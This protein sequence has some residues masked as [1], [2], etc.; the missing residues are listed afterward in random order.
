MNLKICL[1]KKVLLFYA[2][3]S[4]FIIYGSLHNVIQGIILHTTPT[5][6]IGPFSIFGFLIMPFLLVLTYIRNRS[7]IT[8]D[9]MIIYKSVYKF[10]DYDFYIQKKELAF[11]DRPITSLFKKKYD[12][13]VIKE[14]GTNDAVLVKDLEIF[15]KDI[16]NLKKVLP[17]KSNT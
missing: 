15:N 3:L 7:V 2:V 5:Y 13:L 9:R 14:K 8:D 12:E 6:R 16:E 10:A 1:A 4:P 11:K 17:L